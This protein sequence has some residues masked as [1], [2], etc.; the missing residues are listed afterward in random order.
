MLR[1]GL[2]GAVA[3]LGLTWASPASAYVAN[4]HWTSTALQ[5]ST[6]PEGTPVTL[7]WSIVP[8]GTSIPYEG[9]S[10]LV[11][12]FNSWYGS[13]NWLPMIQQ[14]FDRWSELC[15]VTLIYESN[16]DG[17][18]FGSYTGVKN[19]RG[20]IRLG[21]T[22]ID[23][24]GGTYAQTGYVPNAD[25]T[26]DTADSALWTNSA[27]NYRN[28]FNTLEHEIGHSLGLGHVFSSNAAFL[29]ETPYSSLPDG[30]Q[31][32]DILGMHYHFGDF[33]EKS[34]DGAGNGTIATATDLG[35]IA[36]GGSA[37][38]GA[39]GGTGTAVSSSESDF[40]SITNS[41][42]YDFFSFTID[43][44]SAV[45]LVLTPLGPTYNERASTS[46][47]YTTVNT[48]TLSDLTLRLYSLVGG[49]SGLLAESNANPAGQAE[50]ILGYDLSTAGEYYV[51]VSGAQD[52]VQLYEINVAV[53][54]LAP[55]L[56]GDYN[57][58]GV[59]NA[60][61]FTVW[62]DAVAA[63]ATSL[64]NDATP[65]T[66]DESDF[67]YWRVHFGES[68]GGAAAAASAQVPEPATLPLLAFAA[69]GLLAGHRRRM[70]FGGW[71]LWRF[72][73]SDDSTGK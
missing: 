2:L 41:A 52:D 40:V 44:P 64:P 14:S 70:A 38:L 66:V 53:N 13:S 73:E 25:L 68:T 10:N 1:V 45:D 12:T 69:L 72:Q 36:S 5:P 8:D 48:S 31:L 59:V 26:V 35:L 17:Y 65:D 6:G 39:D 30:P 9:S 16:D 20:D 62:R 58:D 22:N 37:A 18:G 33:Y 15:G 51:R 55:V 29:M 27:N 7:T 28:F 49:V 71:E 11:S 57:E 4:G 3:L 23:G 47:P 32:D 54:G 42:D 24:V 34:H 50:S 19:V 63:G 56:A 67:Q 21:G 60:A 46:D 61:D 43:G